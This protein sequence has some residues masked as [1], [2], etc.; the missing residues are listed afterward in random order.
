VVISLAE[1]ERVRE[2]GSRPELRIN[3]LGTL[4]ASSLALLAYLLAL[5]LDLNPPPNLA[6]VFYTIAPAA[7]I[8]ATVLL[9]VRARAEQ[10]EPLRGVTAGLTIASVALVLQLA[11]N[12]SVAPG[13]GIFETGVSA[14]AILYL[15]W[16]LAL[17]GGVAGATMGRPRTNRRRVGLVIGIALAI[18]IAAAVPSS[19]TLVYANG[20][21]SGVL[22]GLMIT[23][24]VLTLLVVLRWVRRSGL[25]PT[26]TRGWITVTLVLSLYDLVLIVIGRQRL[27]DLWW[28]SQTLR[29]VTFVV[30]LGGLIVNTGRQLQRLE[31][32]T[33]TELARAEGEVSSWAEVTERLLHATSALSGAVTAD[34]VAML[35]SAAAAGAI[36][37]DDAAVYLLDRQQPGRFRVLGILGDKPH[38]EWAAQIAGTLYTDVMSMHSPFFLETPGQIDSFYPAGTGSEEA[39]AVGA[40]AALPL[41]AGEKTLGSLVLTSPRGR[42]F[43]RLEREL[44]ESDPRPSIARCSTSS[45]PAWPRSCSGR[46]CRRACRTAATSISRRSTCRRRPRSRSA[47]TG[48]TCWRSTSPSCC[49]S[50]A[51]SWARAPPRRRRWASCAVPSARWPRSTPTPPRSSAGSTSSR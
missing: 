27:S 43:R 9:A 3:V 8:P 39:R 32:Y 15:Y 17:L 45:S 2:P 18:V 40:A 24:I 38:H 34:D 47:A 48:T 16:H 4:A 33:T 37:V 20:D 11:A 19:W 23:E 41:T 29:S 50:S 30:L 5:V 25:R 44:P 36:E 14:S 28:A 22:V 10:D 51:T 1:P 49:W 42:H 35:M 26:A 13:G 7:A 21:Y 31:R 6:I 12:R 46:C